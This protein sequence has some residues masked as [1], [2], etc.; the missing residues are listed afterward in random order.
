MTLGGKFGIFARKMKLDLLPREQAY[1]V[2]QVYLAGAQAAFQ[3]LATASNLPAVQA[4]AVWSGLQQEIMDANL[5]PQQVV[6]ESEDT[7]P[8][9]GGLII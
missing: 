5:K 8:D 3:I 1:G 7:P 9:T 6:T 4:R 2:Q